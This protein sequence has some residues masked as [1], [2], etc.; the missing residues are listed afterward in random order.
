MSN[1]KVHLRTP[2]GTASYPYLTSEDRE[3][4]GY[5]VRLI[6]PMSDELTTL[7]DQLQL[8][9]TEKQQAQAKVTAKGKTKGQDF[10]KAQSITQHLPWFEEEDD[11]GEPTG[12]IILKLKTQF[13]PIIVDATRKEVDDSVRI[14]GGS[15]LKVLFEPIPYYSPKDNEVGV[16]CRIKAV[17]ILELKQG[18]GGFA[19]GFEDE[20]G[21]QGTT[22]NETTPQDNDEISF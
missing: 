7:L 22:P 1:K 11:K 9:V 17:Q 15:V 8:V 5:K 10:E 4:G 20:E 18:T 2:S 16:T 13:R 12:N 19:N 14:F 3:Y 6:I 21:Y